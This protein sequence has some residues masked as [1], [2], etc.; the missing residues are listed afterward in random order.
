MVDIRKRP[1]KNLIPLHTA[2]DLSGIIRN[3][4]SSYSS[5]AQAIHELIDNAV[6]N[7]RGCPNNESNP[8]MIRVTVSELGEDVELSVEDSGSGIVDLDNAFRVAGTDEQHTPLNEHGQGLKQSLAYLTHHGG[9]WSVDTRND[10]DRDRN[11]YIRIA[12]PHNALDGDMF[13]EELPGWPGALGSTGTIIRMT[14]PY[15]VFATLESGVKTKP[16][17][18]RL[19]AILEEDLRYTYA[20]ILDKGDASIEFIIAP[21]E[22]KASRA[23]LK[24]LLPDWKSDPAEMG[25]V[26]I[27]LGGGP[28]IVSGEYGHISP[29]EDAMTHYQVGLSTSGAVISLNGRII[30]DG[31]VSDIWG[32]K[33]HPSGNDFLLRLDVQSDTLASLPETTVEKNGFR[34]GD[35][36]LLALYQWIRTHIPLPKSKE[37]LET[38]LFRMLEERLR[39]DSAYERISSEVPAFKKLG[40]KDR[41]DLF[42]CTKS[43]IATVYEGKARRTRTDDVYQTRRCWDGAVHDGLTVTDAVLVGTNH[44]PEVHALVRYLNEQFGEDGRPYRIR[45]ETWASLGIDISKA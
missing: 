33:R 40:A 15:N 38:R 31:L 37:K 21:K 11:C 45:L 6:S 12:P 27:D 24:P 42:T 18:T 36:R 17:F 20:N 43:G 41:I 19:A 8:H 26:F 32:K 39:M 34:K 10:V 16:L 2:P 35:P 28:V 3:L 14:C 1:E 9:A 7:F 29:A 23:V 4:G 13:G 30:A 5:I 44:P 25:P 22:G